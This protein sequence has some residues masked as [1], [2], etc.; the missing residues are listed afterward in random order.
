MS[1]I[2]IRKL[3]TS[4]MD[5]VI[6]AFDEG[7]KEYNNILTTVKLATSNLLLHWSG[8][9]RKAFEKD[10]DV[11]FV[12]LKDIED[13]LTELYNAL[14]DGLSAYTTADQEIGKQLTR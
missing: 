1:E 2:I 6:L 7:I 3:D 4:K 13:I 9:G 14:T 10:Y 12:Q 5:A 11:I 8:K